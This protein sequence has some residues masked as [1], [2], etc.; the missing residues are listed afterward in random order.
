MRSKKIPDIVIRR[1]PLYL[2]TL[3]RM[4]AEG[5]EITS[6]DQLAEQLRISS[7]LI[8]KDL[9]YF[10]EFGKQGTGYQIRFL[11]EQLQRILKVDREWEVALVGAGNLGRALA[12]YKG[13][14]NRGFCIVAV[15][16]NDPAK[17]GRRLGS[18]KVQNASD[19]GFVRAR[20]LKIAML[21][22][23]ADHAQAVADQLVEAGI[24]AVLSYA[25]IH[26]TVPDGVYVQYIDPVVHLQR[27]TYYLGNR[28]HSNLKG[29]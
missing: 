23:P 14:Y 29:F 25:P 15:Y 27:M 24:R 28:K 1:L 19:L 13:F 10:G 21:A 17:I 2:R 8:R 18:L 7:A 9:S 6:S 11:Q 12:H 22:V 5:K 26:L 3:A 4:A 20:G 16:D